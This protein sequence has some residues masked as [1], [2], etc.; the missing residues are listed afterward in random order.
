M[1]VDLLAAA[2]ALIFAYLLGAVPFSYLVARTVS[3]VDLRRVGSG[4]VSG[5]GVGEASGFWPMAAA[6]LLDIGKGAAAVLPLAGTRPE[7]AALAAGAAV[8]GHNWSPFLRAAGGRGIS[9]AMGAA[10]V[11]AWPGA[12]VLLA[13]LAV[14]KLARYTSVGSFVSQAALTPIL[15]VTDGRSGLV[16]GLA[17]VVPM[18]AKRVAGNRS[19]PQLTAGALLYRLVRDHDWH[20]NAGRGE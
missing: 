19:P 6:G 16:L 10:A 13:G 17:T 15:A 2:G 5:T 4:T 11:L 12:V 9:P 1:I 3:G 20:E 18:W 7:V 8:A 14:G